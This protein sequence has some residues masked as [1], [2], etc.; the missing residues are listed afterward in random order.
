M[1]N[2]W[3]I[4]SVFGIPLL[5]HTSWFFVLALFTLHFGSSWQ[6]QNWRSSTAWSAGFAMALLLF[7]SVLLHELGHCLVARSQGIS[8]RSITLFLFGGV[9]AIESES[10]TP[11]QAFHV[12]IAGP[13]VSF[14]LCLLLLL[15]RF[16]LPLPEPAAIVLETLASINLILALFNM[17]P[18]LPLDG[19]QVLKAAIWQTTGSRQKGVRW[20]ARVGQTLC[21]IAIAAGITL[22]F[23]SSLRA[24]SGLWIALLGYFGI[25]SAN[26]YRRVANLQDALLQL[27]AIDV[28]RRLE[29]IE[30]HL[31]LNALALRSPATYRVVEQDRD[32]GIIWPEAASGSCVGTAPVTSVME[33]IDRLTILDEAAS[34][35]SVVEQLETVRRVIVISAGELI[36]VIDRGDVVEAI[37]RALKLPVAATVVDRVR[38]ENVYP[39]GLELEAIARSA[40]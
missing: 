14:G 38:A 20:A 36:G 30:S 21:W 12:A 5:L 13:A 29:T 2:Y 27:E 37:G 40:A 9:A 1:K 32:C 24:I 26:A 34:L 22:Y 3:Q 33:S 39:P 10:K 31:D 35:R 19:G 7:A 18:G 23:V 8:V 17:I 6:Q 16:V 28:M 4:G 15:V 25:R 11:R